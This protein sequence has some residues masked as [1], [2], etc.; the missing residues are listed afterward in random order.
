M[1]LLKELFRYRRYK[2]IQGRLVRRLTMSGVWVLF[3]VAAYQ[4]LQ[5]DFTWVSRWC[6]WFAGLNTQL[7]EAADAQLPETVA[8]INDQIVA[9]DA[10]FVPFFTFCTAGLILAFGIWFGYRLVNW[11]HFADFL[12]SVEGE[13]AKVSWPS[14]SELKSATIVV[15]MVFF[16]LAAVLYTY[17]LILV[18]LLRIIGIV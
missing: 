16:F 4:C 17:D 15:L 14:P 5:M 1:Q 3:A 18:F 10:T 8:A 9:F 6:T 2:A 7:R 12:I 13:M 11:E